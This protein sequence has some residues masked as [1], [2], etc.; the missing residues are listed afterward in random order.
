M[1]VVGFG[2]LVDQNFPLSAFWGRA[3]KDS[4]I[5]IAVSATSMSS[6]YCYIAQPLQFALSSLKPRKFF[7]EPKWV[8]WHILKN[9]E[10]NLKCSS[11]R[12]LKNRI[13]TVGTERPSDW[14]VVSSG[15]VSDYHLMCTCTV[16]RLT[17]QNIRRSG[18]QFVWTGLRLWVHKDRSATS[19]PTF[20]LVGLQYFTVWFATCISFEPFLAQW[21]EKLCLLAFYIGPNYQENCSLRFHNTFNCW[22]L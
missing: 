1:V 4:V 15:L 3:F 17:D 7:S 16:F 20:R 5:L 19:G 11:I 22:S 9:E 13:A 6:D 18:V 8:L 14:S 10:P 21:Y 2:L 12:V